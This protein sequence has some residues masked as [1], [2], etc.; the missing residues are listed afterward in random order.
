MAEFKLPYYGFDLVIAVSFGLFI[1]PHLLKSIPHSINVHPSLLPQ[2]RGAAPIH[3]AILN[4][5][6]HTGVS[7]QTISPI[8]FDRGII[9]EQ[10][11]AIPIEETDKLQ[12]LWARLANIGADLLLESIRKRSYINPQPT[13][14]FTEE[15]PAPKIRKEVVWPD[16][17]ADRLERLDRII[18]PATGAIDLRTGTRTLIQIRGISQR[19]QQAGKKRPGDYFLARDPVSGK[20]RMVVVC[21]EGKTVFVDQVQVAGKRWIEGTEFVESSPD[22]FWKSRFVPWRPE[23][24]DHDPNSYRYLNVSPFPGETNSTESIET[25]GPIEGNIDCANRE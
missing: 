7:L 20:M 24:D 5:D 19:K 8:G 4:G 14:T 13:H 1:L 6:R 23:Y 15:S 9:F 17:P 21:A 18:A 10:S 12:D 3:H 25:T 2:Y 16:F 11:F 22:R